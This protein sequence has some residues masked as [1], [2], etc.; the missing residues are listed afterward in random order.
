MRE[1]KFRARWKDTGEPILDFNDDYVIDVCNDDAFIVEQYTG[2][3][4]KNGVEIYEGDII[5]LEQW[6]PKTYAV[7]FHKGSFCLSNITPYLELHYIEGSD[8][9]I[10]G[11]IYE[12]PELLEVTN[13]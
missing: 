1:I 4:D 11:N 7:G 10:I 9:Q 8:A 2:L 5:F 13:D 12:N 3:N 6:R